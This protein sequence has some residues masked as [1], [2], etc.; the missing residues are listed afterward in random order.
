M[1]QKLPLAGKRILVTRARHQAGQLTSLLEALGAEIIEIPAIEILPPESFEPFDTALRSLTQYQWMIV[2]STNTV[3]V[4]RE[5]MQTLH[6][7][8]N[9]FAHLKIAAVG[10]GTTH[11]LQELGITVGVTPKEYVAESLIAALGDQLA[12]SHLLLARAAIARDIIPE[13]LA[14]RGAHVDIV[15][16]YRTVIP[17][18][19]AKLI[20][21]LFASAQ[22]LPHAVTFTSSSTV[23]NFFLLLQSAGI[24]H[25]PTEMKAISI[26]PITSQTLQDHRWEPS[27]EADPHD[28]PGLVAAVLSTFASP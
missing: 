27:A 20:A 24:D 10:S 9:N 2:T 18:S 16:A 13:T 15:D 28:L 8:A 22:N 12:G 23:T 21:E 1:N 6:L 25:A 19:S 14:A 17:E 11:A 3:R 4:L 5:L 26:G 7:S